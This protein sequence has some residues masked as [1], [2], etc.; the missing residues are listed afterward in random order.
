MLRY[1]IPGGLKIVG[2]G[3]GKEVR[4][5][6]RSPIDGFVTWATR[7]DLVRSMIDFEEVMDDSRN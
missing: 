6:S 4:Y 2:R 7:L 3:E 5:D 1:A